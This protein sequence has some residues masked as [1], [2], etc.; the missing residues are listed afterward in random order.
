VTILAF[1]SHHWW[2]ICDW[3]DDVARCASAGGLE[4]LRWQVLKCP[5]LHTGQ[6]NNGLL[7]LS[8][9]VDGSRWMVVLNKINKIT[10]FPIQA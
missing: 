3:L 10:W 6:N 4:H 2:V 8:L 5:K 1:L 9:G 7:L